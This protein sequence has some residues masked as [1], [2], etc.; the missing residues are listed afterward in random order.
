M[1]EL[2]NMLAGNAPQGMQAP[3]GTASVPV[4]DPRMDALM[5]LFQQISPPPQTQNPVAPGAMPAQSV[6]PPQLQQGPPQLNTGIGISPEQ[7]GALAQML[8]GSLGEPD[9]P[10]IKKENRYHDIVGR[11]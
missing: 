7:L 2:M 5:Q 3:T 1:N 9:V 4:Q 8:L 10:R 11:K 6:V